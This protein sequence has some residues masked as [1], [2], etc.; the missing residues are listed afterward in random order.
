MALIGIYSDVH[1]SHNS[2]IIPTFL[3]DDLYTTRLKMCRESIK[4]AYKEFEKQN[5][6]T[7]INCGDLFNSHTIS[8][9]ELNTYVSLIKDV[10]SPYNSKWN[11]TLDYTISGN[12]DKFNNTFNSLDMLR[13]TDYSKLVNEYD[14]FSLDNW[15]CYIVSFYDTNEFVSI[16]HDML[17]K[18]PRKNSKALIFM[19]GDINGSML[20]G[21]KRIENHIGTDFLTNYFDVVINGHIHCHELI[22]KQNNKRIYNIGSLTSHSFADSNNHV[23]ACYIFNTETEKI[24]QIKN[25]H[26]ILFKSYEVKDNNDL[27]AMIKDIG[28]YL[29]KLIIKIKCPI[30]IK[31]VIEHNIANIDT[32]LKIKFIFTYNKHANIEAINESTNVDNSMDIK[33]EFIMFLSSRDDLKNNLDSYISAIS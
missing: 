29:N 17:I 26:A 8:S 28:K 4:W 10:Y 33:D 20:S 5:V 18:Y 15:D 12:H 16:I 13:L 22:Y 32:I 2:S 11:P 30:D 21:V 24:E 1:I 27:E 19:H 3:N 6:D 23:P 7:V 25:P 14:Y 9:D 31:E